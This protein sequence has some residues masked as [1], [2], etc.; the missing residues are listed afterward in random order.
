MKSDLNRYELDYTDRRDN[1]VASWLTALAWTI[2]AMGTVGSLF[3][4][5]KEDYAAFAVT[6]VAAIAAGLLFRGVAE[7]IRLLQAI[8]LRLK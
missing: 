2:G 8:L 6:L 7:M 5:V 4:L 1:R 3:P